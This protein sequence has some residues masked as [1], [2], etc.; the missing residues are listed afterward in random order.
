MPTEIY[1]SSIILTHWGRM[2]LNHTS[3]TAYGPDNYTAD[4][5]DTGQPPRPD[6]VKSNQWQELYKGHPCYTPGKVSLTTGQHDL[7]KV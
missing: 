6:G 3:N 4:W 1:N 7:T 2:D 5:D